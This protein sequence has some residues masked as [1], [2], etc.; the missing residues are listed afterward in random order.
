MYGTVPLADDYFRNNKLY[1]RAWDCADV[2]AKSKA[3]DMATR[4]IDLL[5][6]QDD[7]TDPVQPNQFPRGGST[8]VPDDILIATYECA[9]A[10]LDGVD[11]RREMDKLSI[12]SQG[13]DSVRVTYD[14]TIVAEH[15]R[16]GI[17]SSLAWTHLK[18][19]LRDA[20]ARVISRVN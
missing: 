11:I 5:N 2:F 12:S 17:A 4:A 20:N 8:V 19:Y 13:I 3:M 1:T 15:F 10:Y 18:P 6:F 16:A 14:R 7:K 9:Y